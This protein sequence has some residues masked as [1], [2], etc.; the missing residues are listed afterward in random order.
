MLSVDYNVYRY[1]DQQLRT[2]A[3]KASTIIYR[4]A[5]VGLD[6][7]S[8]YARPLQEGDQ[9]Q[10]L[11]Y[12]QCDNSNGNNGDRDVILFA[13]GDFEFSLYGIKKT[14]IGSPIF[15]IDDN[16]LILTGGY[17][18]YIGK[19]IG[20]PAKNRV[21]VRLDIQQYPSQTIVCPLIVSTEKSTYQTL[22]AFPVSVVIT[23]ILVWFDPPP[24]GCYLNIGFREPD[25][26][27]IVDNFNLSTLKSGVPANMPIL[28]HKVPANTIIYA[29]IDITRKYSNN[30]GISISYYPLP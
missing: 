18:S 8:G 1:L 29:S 30:G 19:V 20:V 24:I 5:L 13:Q 6:R 4:G 11:A 27:D 15:A 3:V 2:L 12:E 10:G 17:G 26:D 7:A 22:A 28:Q 16:T 9:C 14:D 23:K 21:I 25:P